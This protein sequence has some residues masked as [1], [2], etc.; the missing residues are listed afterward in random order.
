MGTQIHKPFDVVMKR[1]VEADPLAMLRFLGRDGE[2]AEPFDADL[3]TVSPQADS[4]L[5]VRNPDYLSHAEFVS[6][7]KTDAGRKIMY[8]G[9]SAHYNHVLPV[10]STM[11]LLREE[12]DGPAIT[13]RVEYGANHYDYDVVRLW[14]LPTE[15]IL[16]GPTALLPLAPLTKVK[17]GELPSVIERMKRPVARDETPD[18]LWE[19]TLFLLGL[20][21][22]PEH[23]KALMKGLMH[24]M[25]DSS[26]Y[27]EIFEEGLTE[28]ITKGRTESER[29]WLLRGGTKRFGFPHAAT[30]A[31]LETITS[32]DELTRLYDR[33]FEV[34][35]WDELLR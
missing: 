2:S 1:I 14:Q 27:Q 24:N 31:K 6:S 26:I 35:S 4:I 18:R 34:E 28:G 15:V 9:G 17:P 3:S 10:Y 32:P 23:A 8:Y 30:V 20:K 29:E 5:R 25:K 21:L 22:D 13:G 33:L 12:A 11:V 16:N 19:N 7:Y